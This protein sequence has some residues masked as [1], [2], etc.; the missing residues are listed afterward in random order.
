MHCYVNVF[1]IKKIFDKFHG[2]VIDFR[3]NP[4]DRLHKL[5]CEKFKLSGEVEQYVVSLFI[6]IRFFHRIK[7][8][9]EK[10][11]AEENSNR[12]RKSKQE[13]QFMF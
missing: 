2:E 10:L 8:L 4:M 1:S 3:P 13:S 9:N 11:A 5:I 6:K 12:I 7:I